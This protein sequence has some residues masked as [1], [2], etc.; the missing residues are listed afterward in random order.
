MMAGGAAGWQ[1]T[2][3]EEPRPPRRVDCPLSANPDGN[4]IM[5]RAATMRLLVRG[6]AAVAALLALAACTGARPNTAVSETEARGEIGTLEQ[7]TPLAAIVRTHD[8]RPLDPGSRQPLLVQLKR[9]LAKTDPAGLYRGITYSLSATN[10]LPAN[11]IVQHPDLWGRRADAVPPDTELPQRLEKMI[12]SARRSVDIAALQ[13][14]PDGKFLAAFAGGIAAL[15]R[16]GKKIDVR[17]LVGTYPLGPGPDARGLLQQL[18]EAA[19]T[20]GSDV[21]L[22]VAEMRSCLGS[23]KC[24]SFTWNHAKFVVVDGVTALGGGFN[25]WTGDY[26]AEEPVLDLSMQLAGPAAADASRFADALWRFVCERRHG[27]GTGTVQAASL[28]AGSSEIG[29]DCLPTLTPDKPV[30][31]G[32]VRVLSVARL[33]AG[34]TE[35]FA[36][37]NDLARDLLLG[38]ARKS[39]FIA[40]QDFAFTLAQAKPLW[41]ET[42]M[43]R[44]A[45]FL[46]A[47][48]GN[49]FI[50]LS[51]LDAT[52]RTGMDYS[53]SMPIDGVARYLREVVRRRNPA[54]G[55]SALDTLLCKRLHIAPTRF[56]PDPSWP[57]KRPISNH[58]KFFMVDERAFHIGSDNFYPVNLQEFG[59]IVEDRAAAASLK[60]DYWDPLWRWSSAAAISGEGVGDCIFTRKKVAAR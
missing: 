32:K 40:Q 9:E 41:P 24:D 58:A 30:P 6:L 8:V 13:P 57:E 23:E 55:D 48:R 28:R 25:F 47:D 26:L 22:Y 10:A 45:D 20:A 51:N 35:D 16:S 42:T 37:Q 2:G 56:G 39:I 33:G 14:A 19:G 11:W 38:A 5:Q 34:I 46:L 29:E 31:K 15:A 52:S 44:L 27:N 54:L 3:S 36:N 17:V 50:V 43:A 49:L 7:D 18:A 4:H 21:S 12:A 1:E 60:R 53:N 59:W